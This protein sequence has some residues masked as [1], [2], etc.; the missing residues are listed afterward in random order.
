MIR[1]DHIPDG[2]EV[3]NG[4]NP[5][6]NH[7]IA[8]VDNQGKLLGGVT[9]EKFTG[10]SITMH[11][12]SFDKRWLTK[13]LLWVIFHYPFVRLGCEKVL[14]FTPSTLGDA[15]AFNKKIG[16]IE[17]YR[18]EDACPGGDLVVLSMRRADCRWL[19]IRPLGLRETP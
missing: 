11:V 15:I 13:D 9:Y 3:T 12:R 19:G 14:G 18:I 17:E 7:V 1:F 8:R 10:A 6:L 4:F 2:F 5:K 16:F